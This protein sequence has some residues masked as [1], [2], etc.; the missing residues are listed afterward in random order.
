MQTLARFVSDCSFLARL[1]QQLSAHTGLLCLWGLALFTWWV[2][3]HPLGSDVVVLDDDARMHIYWM[4][5]FQDATLFPD[6]PITTYMSSTL[7]APW[8]YQVLCRLGSS[9][10]PPLL[11]TQLLSLALVLVSLWLLDALLRGV[12][13]SPA[14]RFVGGCLFLFYH[15]HNVVHNILGGFARSFA[16]PILLLCVLFLQRQRFREALLGNIAALV[17]Y[18]PIILNTLALA[19]DQLLRRWWQGCIYWAFMRWIVVSVGRR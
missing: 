17:L 1:R 5:R 12:T 6:D 18:P 19:G 13:E 4:A 15:T 2:R 3:Y 16:V 8:G 7:F 9:I 14:A 11:F 10:M